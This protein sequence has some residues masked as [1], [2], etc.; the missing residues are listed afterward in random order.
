[1]L[2]S[3]ILVFDEVKND[4]DLVLLDWDID[5]VNDGVI[6]DDVI[7]FDKD[8]LADLVLSIRELIGVSIIVFRLVLFDG[9]FLNKLIYN[10][11]MGEN[12]DET[13]YDLIEAIENEIPLIVFNVE[14]EE[15]LI[16]NVAVGVA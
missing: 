11:K 2:E 6:D 15:F 7:F 1:M 9:V 12:I 5:G 4:G 10:Y 3:V 13:M 8:V 14:P 16:S